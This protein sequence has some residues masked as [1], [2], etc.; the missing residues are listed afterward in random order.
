MTGTRTQAPA[1][2]PVLGPEAVVCPSLSAVECWVGYCAILY[3]PVWG[4]NT[5][6]EDVVS[7]FSVQDHTP[8][9]KETAS[10]LSC[11]SEELCKCEGLFRCLLGTVWGRK[12]LFGS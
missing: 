5:G 1:L 2:G 6:M 7:L 12:S 4:Y 8:L 9:G 10:S 3:V 11:G